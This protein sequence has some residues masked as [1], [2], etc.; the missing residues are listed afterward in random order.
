[1]GH[2]AKIASQRIL[3]IAEAA[4]RAGVLAFN[5]TGGACPKC[6]CARQEFCYCGEASTKRAMACEAPQPH[7]HRGCAACGFTW[8][9]ECR[10]HDP[11]EPEGGHTEANN[12]IIAFLAAVASLSSEAPLVL[13]AGGGISLPMS[14]ILAHR[15]W[16]LGWGVERPGFLTVR[17]SH[18][19]TVDGAPGGDAQLPAG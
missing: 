3:R 11:P 10:D 19:A 8:L 4:E 5:A 12:E 18:P 6:G 9:E 16:Q 17:A 14:V 7:I 15:G 13:H 2:D 1:M